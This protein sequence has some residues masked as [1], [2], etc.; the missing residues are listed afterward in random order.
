MSKKGEPAP[1]PGDFKAIFA[2]RGL[3]RPETLPVRKSKG[4]LKTA[5][6]GA[7]PSRVS[8]LGNPSLAPVSNQLP[9]NTC[10]AHA[11]CRMI[12]TWARKGGQKVSLDA[13]CVHQCVYGYNCSLP[14]V[15]ASSVL[16]A[17]IR[18]DA[19]IRKGFVAGQTC[20]ANPEVLDVPEMVQ[21]ESIAAIKQHLA[22]KG[23]AVVVLTLRE[24][25]HSLAR[26]AI[27][28]DDGSNA[29]TFNH[30]VLVIGYDDG[31][32]GGSWLC[33]NSF[34]TGWGDNGCFWLK[35]GSGQLLADKNHGAFI[36]A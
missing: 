27:Y 13:E 12:E 15:D 21:I 33:Q 36:V 9:Y 30:A 5:L 32:H 35:Y 20:P 34:G 4:K 17:M 24:N 23:P 25:F 31:A 28:A 26:P 8:W 6:T 18:D 14:A 1:K 29:P 3:T 10:V 16:I 7:M 2:H 22:G 19:P 11:A